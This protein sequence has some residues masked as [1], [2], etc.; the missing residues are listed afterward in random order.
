MKKARYLTRDWRM[1]EPK[2]PGQPKARSGRRRSHVDGG[3]LA[4]QNYPVMNFGRPAGRRHFT[5]AERGRLS[6]GCLVVAL[7]WLMARH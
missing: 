1:V 4:M 7:F 5:S 2:K 3:Y 6:H